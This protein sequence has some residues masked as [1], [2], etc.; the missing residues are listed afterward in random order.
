MRWSVHI[1][2]GTSE[3]NLPLGRQVAGTLGSVRSRAMNQIRT[4]IAAS[5]LRRTQGLAMKLA[6]GVAILDDLIQFP[7]TPFFPSTSQRWLLIFLL[8]EPNQTRIYKYPPGVF[9]RSRLTLED[10]N[11]L[12]SLP[13]IRSTPS[14]LCPDWSQGQRLKRQRAKGWWPSLTFPLCPSITS[15]SPLHAVGASDCLMTRFLSFVSLFAFLQ[16]FF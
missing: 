7:G 5:T 14:K 2:T 1:R 6:A 4:L 13:S 16:T 10:E 8:L 3:Q 15:L 12:T 9:R 11:I